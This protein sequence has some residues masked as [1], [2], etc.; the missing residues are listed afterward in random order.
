M[1]TNLIVQ[2]VRFLDGQQ[3]GWVEAQ[4][5]DANGQNH[6]FHDKV[7]IF[8]IENL[9]PTS[10]YPQP[11]FVRCEA[12]SESRDAFGLAVVHINTSRPDG[13]ESTEGLSEFAVL[14]AQLSD[15]I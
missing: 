8:T 6:T 11:G 14:P 13:V 9:N 5:R 15:C 7:P 1:R 10:T 3:P 12:S 2:I 4:F